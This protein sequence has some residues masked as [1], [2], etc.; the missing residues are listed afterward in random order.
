MEKMKQMGQS[1]YLG[2]MTI[3]VKMDGEVNINHIFEI[4]KMTTSFV[5]NSIIGLRRS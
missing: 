5:L 3:G 1:I 4:F 2:T